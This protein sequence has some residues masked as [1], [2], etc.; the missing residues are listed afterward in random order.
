MPAT[1]SVVAREVIRRCREL[2][3]CSNVAGCTDRA[4]LSP[5]MHEVHRR[6]G[7]WMADAGMTVAVDAAGN[8]RGVYPARDPGRASRLIIGSHLDTVPDAGAFDG[9][10]GV[11]MGVAAVERLAGRRLPFAIEV[12]GFSEEEGVRFGQP[13]IGSRAFVGDLD[14]HLLGRRDAAGLSVVDA[15]RAFALDP[16]A[17]PQARFQPP[18]LGYLEFHI[19]QGP[20]LER[21]GLPLA[22][23]D[24]IAGQSRLELTFTGAAN[25]AGTTP[26]SMRRDALAGAAEWIVAVEREA[27]S[28]PG[29][30]ATVG[31]IHAAPGATNVIPGVCLVSLDLRHA[32]DDV[33]SAARERVQ[34]LAAGIAASRGLTLATDVRS[35]RPAAPMDRRL[36][37]VLADAVA[38]ARVPVHRMASGAGHDAMVIA[39]H[40]P[41][42]MLFLRT[43]GGISHHPD[44]T[45]H[46]EDVATAL[47]VASEAIAGLERRHG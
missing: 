25:H 15:I 46:E 6:L 19:E 31:R 35:E 13:F 4:F 2:A 41:T 30:V 39:A 1:A 20:V 11:V 22:V 44:E 33:R 38:R 21:L 10:L 7:Q 16:S 42:A 34:Q 8:L 3:G 24:A 27:E 18:V 12:V 26:M 28:T 36:S 37:M 40:M 23:V 47:I 14:D 45:V 5:A 43:P 32:A 29:L 9:I 17:L